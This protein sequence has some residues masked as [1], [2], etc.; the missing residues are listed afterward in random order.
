MLVQSFALHRVK[1]SITAAA[2][3][4]PNPELVPAGPDDRWAQRGANAWARAH[5]INKK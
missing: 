2:P 1:N 3:R 5:N 4:R